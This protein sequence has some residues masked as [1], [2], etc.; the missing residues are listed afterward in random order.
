MN[1]VRLTPARHRLSC[2]RSASGVGDRD[3]SLLAFFRRN[4]SLLELDA[5]IGIAILVLSLGALVALT[6]WSRRTIGRI[7]TRRLRSLREILRDR[8]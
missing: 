8:R 1:A 5:A 6:L 3:P 7:A 4:I 2:N